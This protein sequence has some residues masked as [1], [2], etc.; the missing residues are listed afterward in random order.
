MGEALS[1]DCDSLFFALANELPVSFF[2]RSNFPK[3]YYPQ[4]AS[5]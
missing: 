1:L 3:A 5:V 2:I 4:G